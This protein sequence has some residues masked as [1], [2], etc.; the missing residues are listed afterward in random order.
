[1]PAL[2][3]RR[4][5]IALALAAATATP[6]AFAGSAAPKSPLV[7]TSTPVMLANPGLTL[8]S[9]ESL[10]FGDAAAGNHEPDGWRSAI[11]GGSVTFAAGDKGLTTA[12]MAPGTEDSLV[13]KGE[14]GKPGETWVLRTR[15]DPGPTHHQPATIGVAFLQGQTLLDYALHRMETEADGPQDVEIRASAPEGTD[16]VRVRWVFSG[17]DLTAPAS[18][19][20]APVTLERLDATSRSRALA[21]PH[22][23]LVTIETFRADHSSLFGYGR[24][25]TP[26][27]VKLAA[28]GAVF[29][30]HH[31]QAPYT[32]PSLSSLVTSRYPASLGITENV[33]P[34]P[35][36]ATTMA[37]MFAGDGYV[38]GGFVSQYLLSAHF[39]FN[40]GFH[41]FYNHPNDTT[42]DTIFGDLLPWTQA[43]LADNTFV[44]THLFDPHGPYRPPAEFAAP[45]QKDGLW[46]A[47]SATLTAGQKKATGP[48]IPGYVAE[49]GQLERRQ[50]VA[51]Y[52]GELAY[53]DNRIGQLVKWIEDHGIAE[54]SMLIVTAD[55]GES[56]TEH[57]RYF[58]HGSLYDHDLH[59]PLVVWAPGRIK[60]GTV[61]TERTAHLDLV[62]TMLDYAGMPIPASVKGKSLRPLIETGAKATQPYT[63]A[64]VGQGEE[65]ALAVYSDDPLTLLVDF[66][67]KPIEAYDLAKDP[68]Q[69]ENLLPAR[70]ADAER[71]AEGYRTWMAAQLKDDAPKPKAKAKAKPPAMSDDER[72]RLE[73]LGYLDPEEAPAPKPAPKPTPKK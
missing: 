45:F 32:R 47:D 22:L 71:I 25:T 17:K 7:V 28:D 30:N 1:M 27:L 34:L 12:T 73:A 51:R 61:V 55:H 19:A 48:F 6:F 21:L 53:V 11:K 26:N 13:S 36:S 65:E 4:A 42:V 39:G 56:M 49:E 10:G 72:A 58:C 43:H 59:V 33:P 14:A 52:D 70:Q 50:Y 44:W 15:I 63:V 24:D 69:L 18:F 8:D 54:Q 67:G 16:T 60:A 29:K 57:G 38:T 62:P 68:G 3:P 41:Y 35:Q 9:G 37:E 20:F 40:Q 64:L 23:F 31:P 46:N 66:N 2:S 5:V